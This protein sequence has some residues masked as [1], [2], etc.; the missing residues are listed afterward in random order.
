MK[1][2]KK[3]DKSKK[4]IVFVIIFALLF[5][6]IKITFADSNVYEINNFD[7]LLNAAE[8]SRQEGHQ[9]DT[10][11]LKNDIE[12]T[13]SDQEKLNNNSVKYISFGSSEKPFKGT[14][15]GAGH[16]I[17]N[18]KYEST[19]D[20]KT[21]TGLFSYTGEGAIIKN[22]TLINA[23]I[24]A[25][26]R[27][28][29][30]SG[31]SEGTTFEN[32]TIKDSHLFVAAANNVLTLITDG[33]I[34]GGAIVGEAK[35]SVLYNCETINTTVN[36]NNTSGV[37][38]LSGK[39][40]YLGGLVGTSVST[41]IE[42]SRVEGGLVK[43]YYDV[44]VEALGGNTLYVGGIV[45]QMKEQSKVIDSYSTAEL[46]FYCA[47]YVSVGAGNTGNI[48]GIASAMFGNQNE[49][50]RC[51]YSGKATSRQYNAVIVIPI[52]QDNINISGITNVYEGGKVENTYYKTSSNPG[53]TMNSLGSSGQTGSFGALSDEK[54]IDKE[55]WRTRK[56]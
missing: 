44:A 23:D 1:Q 46:N 42:Y 9:N 29:L 45:G 25:D 6:F 3:V 31:Y 41:T 33:G 27:G 26:Y 37:A 13:E 12:I 19:T 53:V 22:L 7:E 28:G 35:N 16:S 50:I 48:G 39:G 17:S 8:L 14:F 49:I 36:T 11:I 32:I 18:L 5:S 34:R 21:D 56:I 4:S 43:E 52:I 2:I 54:F 20:P 51:V 55:F 15:D 38:A 40:L 10:Y 30:I 24:Q 47:T